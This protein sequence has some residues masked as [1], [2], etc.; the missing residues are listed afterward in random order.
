[1]RDEG[2]NASW[3]LLSLVL[4]FASPFF[5][6]SPPARA[7]RAVFSNPSVASST[8]SGK[9]FTSDPSW[10]DAGS[11]VA[12]ATHTI[13]YRLEMPGVGR[14][15]RQG[16]LVCAKALL[17]CPTSCENTCFTRGRPPPRRLGGLPFARTTITGQ[18]AWRNTLS[19]TLPAKVRLILP[20]P[21]FV[22]QPHYLLGY[23]S[24]SEVGLVHHS[25]GDLHPPGELSER[26]SGLFFDHLVEP[27]I[28]TRGAIAVLH[29]LGQR[30]DID[31]VQLG[32]GAFGYLDGRSGGQLGLLG[33][34]GGQ[35]HLRIQQIALRHNLT[36]SF[37]DGRQVSLAR[38]RLRGPRL[39]LPETSGIGAPCFASGPLAALNVRRNLT[40]QV[41]HEV[42]ST[43]AHEFDN[44]PLP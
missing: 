23:P 29:E 22:G 9:P 24:H 4:F 35:Q 44:L 11:S 38:Y 8:F 1:M 28:I 43:R 37:G 3:F 2:A 40:Q 10:V 20:R 25:T 15:I 5:A 13:R 27:A 39:A 34:V 26:L 30:F 14:A 31:H 7:A 32:G 18:W 6:R 21:R 36:T 19:E 42:S 33:A 41:V 17:A 16:D 12:V